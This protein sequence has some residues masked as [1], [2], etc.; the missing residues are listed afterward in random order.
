M[1]DFA[2]PGARQVAGKEGLDLDDE[3]IALVAAQPLAEEVGTDLEVLSQWNGH[4]R[5]CLGRENWTDSSTVRCS[6]TVAGP[7]VAERGDDLAAPV[8]PGPTHRR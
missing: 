8:P 1:L 4:Q 2:A 3:G 7:S 5:T 6:V